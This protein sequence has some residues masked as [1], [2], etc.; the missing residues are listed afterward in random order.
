MASN[1]QTIDDENLDMK[2]A[3][4]NPNRNTPAVTLSSVSSSQAASSHTNADQSSNA[5]PNT[6]K[7]SPKPQ[8]SRRP[9]AVYV[10]PKKKHKT[11]RRW[12]TEEHLTFC[13]GLK[14]YGRNWEAISKMDGIVNRTKQLVGSHAQRHFINLWRR[15]EPL[16]LKVQESG[17]GY[18]LSGNPLDPNS[19]S[20][21]RP[22]Y[23]TP[24]KARKRY[25]NAIKA[26]KQET[27]SKAKPHGRRKRGKGRYKSVYADHVQEDPAITRKR[28]KRAA[29]SVSFLK[30][31]LEIEGKEFKTQRNAKPFTVWDE[32]AQSKAKTIFRNDRLRKKHS[33]TVH[34]DD[35]VR[36]KVRPRLNPNKRDRKIG[37]S[38]S[39]P[40][41]VEG[42]KPN[43]GAVQ[44][45]APLF[46]RPRDLPVIHEGDKDITFLSHFHKIWLTDYKSLKKQSDPMWT[47]SKC[48]V[49]SVPSIT[50]QPI[51]EQEHVT[52]VEP[53]K[54]KRS[55]KEEMSDSDDD[56]E[57][58]MEQKHDALDSPP[59]VSIVYT[60][61]DEMKHDWDPH[62][63]PTSYN[64]LSMPPITSS[65]VKQ[66]R[67]HVIYF[68]FKGKGVIPVHKVLKKWGLVDGTLRRNLMLEYG[69]RYTQIKNLHQILDIASEEGINTGI[70]MIH[71]RYHPLVGLQT[72][73]GELMDV[74]NGSDVVLF[75]RCQAAQGYISTADRAQNAE[76][77]AAQRRGETLYTKLPKHEVVPCKYTARQ[78]SKLMEMLRNKSVLLHQK[79][80]RQTCEIM[81]HT[82]HASYCVS[83]GPIGMGKMQRFKA[84]TR[85]TKA[86]NAALKLLLY[87]LS[88]GWCIVY[89]KNHKHKPK[90]KRKQIDEN[91]EKDA[92]QEDEVM[93]ESTVQI[94]GNRIRK[95]RN[96]R[97][98]CNAHEPMK[99]KRK[100]NVDDTP[101]NA[102]K[103]P[104]EDVAKDDTL[105]DKVIEGVMLESTDEIEANRIGR[106]RND[107]E[108][109]DRCNQHE[110]MNKKRKLNSDDGAMEVNKAN[111]DRNTINDHESRTVKIEQMDE[112]TLSQETID[113][114]QVSV[115][116]VLKM[117]Q[118]QTTN[119]VLKTPSPPSMN[120][121]QHM[122]YNVQ[123]TPYAIPFTVQSVVTP[124][125]MAIIDMQFRHLQHDLALHTGAFL[126]EMPN[127]VS[128]VV[129]SI[130][131]APVVDQ[132][133][134][135][136]FR[137]DNT[138]DPSS[139]QNETQTIKCEEKKVKEE[140]K[141]NTMDSEMVDVPLTIKK[142]KRINVKIEFVVGYDLF[143]K[144]LPRS[145][146]A[147][148][149]T[150]LQHFALYL[151]THLQQK[152]DEDSPYYCIHTRDTFDLPAPFT[153]EK[154]IVKDREFTKTTYYMPANVTP[155]TPYIKWY[156][157]NHWFQEHQIEKQSLLRRKKRMEYRN[158]SSV[159]S[160]DAE[161]SDDYVD[162]DADDTDD[163]STEAYVSNQIKSTNTNVNEKDAS[164][165]KMTDSNQASTAEQIAKPAQNSVDKEEEVMLESTEQIEANRVRGKPND[166][167]EEDEEMVDD[168]DKEDEQRYKEMK[169]FRRWK[170]TRNGASIRD[171]L[172]SGKRCI[173]IG[174]VAY[175]DFF[176]EDELKEIEDALDII[177]R[178]SQRNKYKKYT[179]QSTIKRS[180]KSGLLVRTKHFFGARYLWHPS[181][182]KR[183][184]RDKTIGCGIRVDVDAK[185]NV[186]F[187][188]VEK[189]LVQYG[190]IKPNWIE[191]IAFNMYHDGTEGIGPHFD[192]EERFDRPVIT[193][194]LFSDARIAFGTDL[195]GTT[196]GKVSIPLPRGCV[197]MLQ[198][199][200]FVADAIKHTVRPCDMYAKSA[201]IILRRFQ[202]KALNEAKELHKQR[203]ES[204]YYDYEEEDERIGK[205]KRKPTILY[206][207]GGRRRKRSKY[208][209]NIVT[210]ENEYEDTDGF[211][212]PDDYIEYLDADE[213]AGNRK[214][215][216]LYDLTRGSEDTVEANDNHNAMDV[217]HLTDDT[218]NNDVP[219]TLIT[220]DD[221]QEI[222]FGQLQLYS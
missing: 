43:S 54:K 40:M 22:K 29:T 95:K 115:D 64:S 113:K 112:I 47:H 93:L 82:N 201:A 198:K 120:H 191:G 41:E 74:L 48:D 67:F 140:P 117:K 183:E 106:K 199:N 188:L 84:F 221:L 80:Q 52:A 34:T 157:H 19:A 15:K 70:F 91:D 195:Y 155:S 30:E 24:Q 104:N 166:D 129:S 79:N 89:P 219:S 145:Q 96:D 179:S 94:Q 46:I 103:P 122:H 35:K 101:I 78:R 177:Q 186:L 87:K 193:V 73:D 180:S 196:N 218:E 31:H 86:Y 150:I 75:V 220:L 1:G 174:A 102:N 16:P 58:N 90:H 83:Q 182:F 69:G 6:H 18:T 39:L 118:E 214:R 151:E 213:N 114:M 205:K 169:A 175:H 65:L 222:L 171:R 172:V 165:C 187:D 207:G 164:D 111:E 13:R 153:K 81:V 184:G 62:H 204:G 44:H 9:K 72:F 133:V 116:A 132:V 160:S 200:S 3:N 162:S 61:K 28:A 17:T 203:M 217:S 26:L 32:T 100:L 23:R 105:R 154:Q 168:E 142:N 33:N 185:P 206:G 110:P 119:T 76:I 97:D 11:P 25:V 88:N 143:T 8:P 121:T 53:P 14:I 138:T 163:P 215:I 71:F 51:T 77:R 128:N 57:M 210:D 161:Q 209:R 190:L 148:L 109:G 139:K 127:T 126:P 181:D 194:R 141:A 63:I 56:I 158:T 36:S 55:D 131:P 123:M 124:Q 38:Y 135:N 107:Y 66:R 137:D 2:R 20:V 99:K 12:T 92:V 10:P 146:Q 147:L 208:R 192:D 59:I 68:N 50:E 125:T 144:Q 156:A 5:P 49:L 159:R 197:L 134:K 216:P 212:V 45:L 42:F 178:R 136:A 85:S 4:T 152:T 98:M 211:C 170:R 202:Q 37:I 149:N 130:V 173:W 189:K 21:Q 176:T 167:K 60:K 27:A 7:P 108:G